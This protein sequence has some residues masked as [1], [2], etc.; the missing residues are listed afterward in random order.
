MAKQ[1]WRN[2]PDRAEEPTAGPT[3]AEAAQILTRKD[4]RDMMAMLLPVCG[5][6]TLHTRTLT[7][8]IEVKVGP[9]SVVIVEGDIEGVRFGESTE[10]HPLG[11]DE[12]ME[13]GAFLCG[14]GSIQKMKLDQMSGGT[15]GARTTNQ[16]AY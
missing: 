6:V 12:L 4:M 15:A 8:A 3:M 11:A 13:A 14:L 2:P 7:S 16:G 5:L 1:K 10:V 9:I